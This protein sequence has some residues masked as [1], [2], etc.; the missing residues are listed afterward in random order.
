[1]EKTKSYIYDN[2][3]ILA[4]FDE[5]G[6]F[7]KYYVHGMGIDN[8]L[9]ML[10]NEFENGRDNFTA[11]YYHKDGMNSIT[12]LTDKDGK[13]VE[14]YIYNAFGKMTI[15]DER[16]NKI[17]AS[18]FDNPYSFTGREHDNETGLHYHRARYYSPELARWISE[19]PIE[20]NG[21]DMN[22]YRYVENNPLYWIDPDGSR[23]TNSNHLYNQIK[24]QQKRNKRNAH[25]AA[26]GVPIAIPR[27]PE[28]RRAPDICRIN[29]LCA[30]QQC[31][32][33]FPEDKPPFLYSD[34][35]EK[36][37]EQDVKLKEIEAKMKELIE[38]IIEK[39]EKDKQKN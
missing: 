18:Q 8:P 33:P 25:T 1:M 39:R 7:E 38:D 30:Y 12:S 35:T 32:K 3:D 9:A 34:Y 16:D 19:D 5:E 29:D 6:L 28:N 10:D 37:I 13:E 15:Y 27:K 22:L 2:E 24:Q 36:Q 21:G 23:R 11:Y 17:E 31:I 20:F 26:P 4:E 14:K